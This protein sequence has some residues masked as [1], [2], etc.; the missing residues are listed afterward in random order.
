MPLSVSLS[1]AVFKMPLGS[2]AGDGDLPALPSGV[3]FWVDGS[4]DY[5]VDGSGDYWVDG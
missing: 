1:I 5:W 4:G 3:C 2:S